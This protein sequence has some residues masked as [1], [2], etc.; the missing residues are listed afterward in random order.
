MGTHITIPSGAL[1][2]IG[3]GRKALFLR[4]KG[5]PLHAELVTERVLEQRNPPT[6]EQGTDRPDGPT[7]A[8]AFREVRSSKR[9]GINSPRTALRRRSRMHSIA[10]VMRV[11]SII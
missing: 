3:D 11:D 10:P 4:N 9:T 5:T 1:V 8:M 6:H 7:R 2:L